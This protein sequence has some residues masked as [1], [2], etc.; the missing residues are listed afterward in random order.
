MRF[1][2]KLASIVVVSSAALLGGCVKVN[3]KS[4]GLGASDDSASKASPA[5]G[6]SSSSSGTPGQTAPTSRDESRLPPAPNFDPDPYPTTVADPWAGV[7][8]DQPRKLSEKDANHWY[9]SRDKH[10][11]T[12]AIDHCFT[13]P[14]WLIEQDASRDNDR[15]TYRRSGVAFA[16]TPDGGTVEPHHGGWPGTT[17]AYTA[18]RTVPATRKNLV[19]GATMW[20]LAFEF[21]HPESQMSVFENGWAIGLVDRVDWDMGFVYLKGQKQPYWI[22]AARVAVLSWRP[23]GKVTIMGGG[24][25]DSIKVAASEVILP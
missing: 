20:S 3:G 19:P 24:T 15:E 13:R 14:L 4:Y 12:A 25:R 6:G 23:G 10:A 7:E 22:S 5:S 17:V 2:A 18:Y 9:A 1:A 21:K 11:C 8:G 16:F